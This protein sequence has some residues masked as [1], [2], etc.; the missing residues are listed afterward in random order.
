[1]G[2]PSQVVD[3][4]QTDY[5]D[6]SRSDLEWWLLFSIAVAGWRS[7]MAASALGR[8]KFYIDSPDFPLMRIADA[9]EDEPEVIE[10]AFGNARFRFTR[11][12]RS[13]IEASR[14]F[15]CRDL[16][17]LTPL[18]L[19]SIHGIGPKTSRFFLFTA[20]PGARYAALDTH[21]LKWLS[22]LGYDA[23]PKSTPSGRNYARIE[24]YFLQEADARGKEPSELDL[25]VWTAYKNGGVYDG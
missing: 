5:S 10:W 18:E 16:R 19:E 8:F 12:K 15:W 24:Q 4:T 6:A 13:F 25:E 17:K 9:M 7:E 11:T 2:T 22:A 3:Y 23:I 20:T 1:M 14:E 21:I